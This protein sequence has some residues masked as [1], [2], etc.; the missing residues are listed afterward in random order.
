[1]KRSTLISITSLISILTLGVLANSA[2]AADLLNV[3]QQAAAKNGTYQAAL[4]TYKAAKDSVPIARGALL[5]QISLPS[6]G[7]S[8]TRAFKPSTTTKSFQL[9]ATQQLFNYNDWATYTQAQYQ[10]KYDAL[11]YQTA[12]Q[13]LI[14]D[15]ATDY[16]AVLQAR[17][18]LAYAQANERQNKEFLD[19]AEQQYR[20]GL[21]AVTD[22]QSAR[23]D[24]ESARAK[25]ID[26]ANTLNDAYQTLSALTGRT[27]SEL[28]L[29]KENFPK[30]TPYPADPAVWAETAMKHNLSALSDKEQVA[31]DKAGISV[32]KAGY[33]PTLAAG[34]SFSHTATS[35]TGVASTSSNTTSAEIN[36]SWSLFSGWSTKYSVDQA[37]QT[38]VADQSTYKQELRN[39][40]SEA[41]SDYLTV[42]SDISQIK[43]Y[44][45]AVVSGEASVKAAK[46]QYQVGTTTIYN[47]LQQQTTLFQAQQQYAS[48]IYTYINDSLKLKADAGLLSIK[49]I[50]GVN[51]W[52]DPSRTTLTASNTNH[53]TKKAVKPMP[54]QK[55]S[56]K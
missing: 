29:L 12:E 25:R 32:A 20:V 42:L 9:S 4:Q 35:G 41:R 38:R 52:L 45:Q 17:D 46:A 27:E 19:Q 51:N 54:K 8:I 49:D 13:N 39:V 15:T 37:K 2:S 53:A 6:T 28:T 56:A 44:K 14:T 21:K 16:F 26:D 3:Y 48:A 18:N 7:N 31:V 1:M 24:Y 43:A 50:Q 30:V 36:A 34:G 11:T 40:N 10:L 33:L 23:A 55:K 47:L 5:P 22:V